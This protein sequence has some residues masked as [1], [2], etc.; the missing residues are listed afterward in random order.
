MARPKTR[1]LQMRALLCIT[2]M[3]AAQIVEETGI[4]QSTVTSLLHR[5]SN[6][7]VLACVRRGVTT[8]LWMTV[9]LHRKLYP[10]EHKARADQACVQ[11]VTH[12]ARFL[13]AAEV[14]VRAGVR[15]TRQAAP[16]GRFEVDLPC[17]TGAIS[18]DLE[19]RR[20]GQAV[21]TRMPWLR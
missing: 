4:P 5:L 9:A 8:P 1:E 2:P 16:A 7:G 14:T 21:D 15:I 12:V 10:G 20:A 18:Q 19:A 11:G 6:L 17:G 13:P 3:T